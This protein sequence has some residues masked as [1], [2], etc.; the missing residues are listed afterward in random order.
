MGPEHDPASVVDP[1]TLAVHGVRGVHVVDA[2]VMPS[3]V[4]GNL[5]GCTIML[6]EKA[7][8]AI[9]LDLQR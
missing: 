3:I 6:A 9:A 2:S 8:A 7:A 1:T 4:S 5:N